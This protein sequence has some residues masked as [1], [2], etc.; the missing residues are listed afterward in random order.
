MS[1]IESLKEIYESIA[2]EMEYCIFAPDLDEDKWESGLNK[3]AP[4]EEP[5]SVLCI[6]NAKVKGLLSILSASFFLLTNEKLYIEKIKEGI[7]FS[8]I[9]SISYREEDKVSLFGKNKAEG[10]IIIKKEGGNQEIL[11][12]NYATK[13]IA[14]FLNKVVSEFKKAP[15]SIPYKSCQNVSKIADIIK[16]NIKGD[17]KYWKIVPD[18]TDNEKNSF[19]IHF[20]K[21]EIRSC[22]A[23]I[24]EASS[25][26][27]LYFTNDFLYY[28][29]S[30][31]NVD[32]IKYEFLSNASY[33]ETEK[34]G[35]DGN[36]F[37]SQN[38]I[39]YDKDKQVFFENSNVEK[40]FA[41]MFNNIISVITG[42]NI[43]TDVHKEKDVFFSILEKWN[44]FFSRINTSELIDIQATEREVIATDDSDKMPVYLCKTADNYEFEYAE[45]LTRVD[46][47]VERL[48]RHHIDDYDIGDIVTTELGS[49]SVKFNCFY[50]KF[51]KKDT[52]FSMHFYVPNL[53]RYRLSLGCS[54]LED[55]LIHDFFYIKDTYTIESLEA[56]SKKAKMENTG[57]KELWSK[58]EVFQSCFDNIKYKKEKK[59]EIEIEIKEQEQKAVEEKIRQEAEEKR[60]AEKKKQMDVILS[61]LN[62]I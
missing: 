43:E 50:F 45:K 54:L 17:E 20:A 14:M 33:F 7:R 27:K 8:E 47:S 12:G 49:G 29:R 37:F 15:P 57:L 59:I 60:I 18:I 58:I 21:N 22:V 5:I 9:L 31:T 13:K 10:F 24:Y 62:E 48:V 52:I 39:V 41:D 42:K 26:E 34:K 51:N 53:R 56:F 2:P 19:I 40:N 36:R 6:G 55:P 35:D 28:K 1:Y 46:V 38:V 16:A 4:Q 23:A 25:D 30:D 3:L 11:K 44:E 32:K 61:K